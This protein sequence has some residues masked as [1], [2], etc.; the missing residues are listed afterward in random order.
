MTL[1]YFVDLFELDSQAKQKKVATFKMSED[2]P[3]DVEIEGD[4]YHPAVEN[5]KGEGIFD[6]KNATPNKLYPQDGMSFLEN[7]KY[8]FRSGYLSASEVQKKVVD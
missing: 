5:L 6:Y 3:N 1:L 7:L 8:N 4:Q 2:S